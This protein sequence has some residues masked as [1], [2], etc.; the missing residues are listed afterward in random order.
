MRFEKISLDIANKNMQV[1]GICQSQ[2]SLAYFL[3]EIPKIEY[4][5]SV[6]VIESNKEVRA[7][8]KI[9]NFRLDI[10]LEV[11]ADEQK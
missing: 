10:T 4:I 9:F 3:R 2:E 6:E 5:K 8:F 1:E 11:P 7:N